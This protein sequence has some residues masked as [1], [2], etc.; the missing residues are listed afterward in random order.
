MFSFL[1]SVFLIDIY[2][3]YT[4]I[5]E[6]KQTYAYTCISNDIYTKKNQNDYIIWKTY[7]Q[8]S[9]NSAS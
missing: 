4:I 2:S 5:S 8:F 7:I 9:R 6:I 1:T 3:K